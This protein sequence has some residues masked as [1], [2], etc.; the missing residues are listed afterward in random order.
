MSNSLSVPALTRLR[1]LTTRVH[2]LDNH[3]LNV[4]LPV[5]A[6]GGVG[7]PGPADP[8]AERDVRKGSPHT[9]G[10]DQLVL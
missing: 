1:S 2:D 9:N 10:I 8:A 5:A 6:V 7:R 3:P 4:Q